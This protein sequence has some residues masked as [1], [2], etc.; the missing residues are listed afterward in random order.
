MI[1]EYRVITKSL[2][3]RLCPLLIITNEIINNDLMSVSDRPTLESLP[4]DSFYFD[5]YQLT[6]SCS[7]GHQN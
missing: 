1:C 6:Y 2:C 7:S 4:P 3:L 5:L